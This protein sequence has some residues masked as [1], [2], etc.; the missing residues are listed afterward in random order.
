MEVK[1]R[2]GD[3]GGDGFEDDQQTEAEE[4]A[5]DGW[6]LNAGSNDGKVLGEQ[7]GLE[8]GG[9]ARVSNAEERGLMTRCIGSNGVEAAADHAGGEGGVGVEVDEDEAAG[10]AIF[11]VGIEEDR[12]GEFDL[13]NA[14]IVHTEG[15]DGFCLKR[16]Y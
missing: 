5:P 14:D 2:G 11:R 16:L 15:I 13:G 3:F 12:A 6:E 1:A 7:C 9:L 10:G 8:C 4:C